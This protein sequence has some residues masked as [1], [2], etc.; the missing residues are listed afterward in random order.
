MAKLIEKVYGEALFELAVEEKRIV[1][2]KRPRYKVIYVI[3]FFIYQ[4]TCKYI[5]YF[6]YIK[7]SFPKFSYMR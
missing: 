3:L 5:S 2:Y 1:H 7:Y 6:T 4:F